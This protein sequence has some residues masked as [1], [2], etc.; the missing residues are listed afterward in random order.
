MIRDPRLTPEFLSK[1]EQHLQNDSTF[2]AEEYELI[3]RMI[4]AW[5]GILAFGAASR[6]IL[7]AL[8]LIAGTALTMHELGDVFRRWWGS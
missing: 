2:T 4:K 8:G 5:R 7:G 1:V 6:W 3:R